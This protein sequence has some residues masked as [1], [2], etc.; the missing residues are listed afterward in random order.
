ML[1]KAYSSSI[2]VKETSESDWTLVDLK[3]KKININVPLKDVQTDIGID[4]GNG[5][6]FIYVDINQ[7]GKRGIINKKLSRLVYTLKNDEEV[8]A[9][10]IYGFVI[11][12]GGRFKLFN[13]K[14]DLLY[15]LTGGHRIYLGKDCKYAWFKNDRL[16]LYDIVE[17]RQLSDVADVDVNVIRY[18]LPVKV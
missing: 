11:R 2:P 13:D 9:M 18:F 1:L 14:G 6:T 4:Y 3:G 17:N 16:R 8:F 10:N 12:G 7:N 15:T 5:K